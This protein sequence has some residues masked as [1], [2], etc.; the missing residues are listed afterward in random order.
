LIGGLFIAGCG[1]NK[2]VTGKSM[3]ERS[4][5]F[6]M[7]QMI[8]NQVNAEWFEGRAKVDYSGE[9]LSMGVSATIRMKKDSVLWLS[10]KKLGF[11]AVRVLITTDSVY[12][13]DRINN[14]YG[15]Q[16]FDWVE[17]QFSIPA[18]LHTLQMIFLGNPI[19]FNTRDL[20]SE[21]VETAYHLFHK[22]DNINSNYW[23]NGKDLSLQQMSFDDE[24][25]KRSFDY[26]LQEYQTTAD[27]QK[28]SY[29]RNLQFDSQETGKANVE[30]RFSEIEFNVP[31]SIRFDIPKRY[32]RID[33]D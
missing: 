9:Y 19:F 12:V 2:K 3:K 21:I 11:E 26:E 22:G 33:L 8:R 15:V 29:F 5:S 17:K 7:E 23:L 14:Q 18:S 6:L 27:K 30:I 1:T 20:Q 25:Y 28:F 16:S 31:K 10:V 24:R 32:T 13:L 4:S